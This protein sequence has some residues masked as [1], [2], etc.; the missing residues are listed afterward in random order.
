MWLLLHRRLFITAAFSVILATT[1]VAQDLDPRAYSHVPVDMTFVVGGGVFSSGAILTDPTLPLEEFEATIWSATAGVGRTFDLFGM[2]AQAFVAQAYSWGDATAT[3]NAI[4]TGV[5]RVGFAD[6]R[7]RFS[8]LPIGAP[9]TSIG[10]F[11]SAKRTTIL[12]VS[13]TVTAPTGA[14]NPQWLIN[15]GTNRWA[16]KPELA[17]SQPIGDRINVD[18]YAGMWFFTTNNEFYPGSTVRSQDPMAAF[19]GHVSYQFTPL[20][21][22]ALDM[23]FYVGG[24]SYLNGVASND[25]QR[26]FRVGGTFVIPVGRLS[27]I[28]VAAS[29]GAIVRV[30]ASFTTIS[31]AWQTSFF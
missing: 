16:F 29:T 8:I 27:S 31:L 19:Q 21:W 15:I 1:A 9:S 25:L 7:F 10:A 5:T 13:L 23:T 22:T 17:L 26:N 12:G 28:K 18:V 14:F 4:D 3:V 11:G 6:T 2:T 20:M 24:N 30:G